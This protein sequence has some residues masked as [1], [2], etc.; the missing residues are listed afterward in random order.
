M[1]ILKKNYNLW[2]VILWFWV[3]ICWMVGVGWGCDPWGWCHM[4][5]CTLLSRE[6]V[7]LCWIGIKNEIKKFHEIIKVC[8]IIRFL[9]IR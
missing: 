3:R 5:F 4:P 2:F 6:I 8:Y 1:N 9:F 7:K